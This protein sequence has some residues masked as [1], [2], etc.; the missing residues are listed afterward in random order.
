MY[1]LWKNNMTHVF[2]QA[3][4][5]QHHRIEDLCKAGN[6]QKVWSHDDIGVVDGMIFKQK[7]YSLVQRYS[8]FRFNSNEKEHVKLDSKHITNSHASCNE[9]LYCIGQNDLALNINTYGDDKNAFKSNFAHFK[10]R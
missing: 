5:Y 4:E 3:P 10:Q 7:I 1:D 6:Q 2:L 9:F 8:R